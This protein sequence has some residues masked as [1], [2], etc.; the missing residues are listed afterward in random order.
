MVLGFFGGDDFQGVGR[1]RLGLDLHFDFFPELFTI[2]WRS[3]G[4]SGQYT[5]DDCLGKTFHVW[6]SLNALRT[7]VRLGCMGYSTTFC[8]HEF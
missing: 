3:H 5:A 4:R 6:S 1:N 7:S 2:F 8:K